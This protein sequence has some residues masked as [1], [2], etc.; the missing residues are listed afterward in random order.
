MLI[1]YVF[2]LVILYGACIGSFL[3]VVVYRLPEG[4][5]LL[6]PPSHCPK[7]GAKLAIY[8]NVPILGWLWLRGRC[9]YCKAPISVQYPL[10]EALTAALFGGLYAAYYFSGLTPEWMRLGLEETWPVLI[11]HLVLLAAL[12]ASTIIDARLYII[13]LQI[14]WF[15]T[16]VALVVLPLA[17]FLEWVPP[18]A[19]MVPQVGPAGIGAGFGATAGLLLALG[20]LQASVLPRSFVELEQE[21]ENSAPGDAPPPLEGPD[22][23]LAHPHPRREVAKEMLFVALPTIGA[24]VGAAYADRLGWQPDFGWRVLGGV[25][26]GYFVGAAVVWYIRILGTLGFGKEAMGLGDVHLVAAI[27][28]VLGPLDAIFAF[29]T[30]PF[31]GLLAAVIMFGAAAVLKQRFKPI[32]YGP[33]LSGAAVVVMLL[34]MHYR[35]FLWP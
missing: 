20:L 7:C 6:N 29:F 15:A 8:D 4:K 14:P 11:V 5:S 22:A 31:F 24:L 13:P 26:C 28:A 19:T 25:L 1:W 10:V 3:N 2:I 34:G 23:W 35:E 33:Y 30:A 27:G 16:A 21:L 9:R 17:A 18:H 12:L 32:P